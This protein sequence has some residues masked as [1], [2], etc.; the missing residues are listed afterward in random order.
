LKP[1][2]QGA[3]DGLCAVYSVVNATR[4]IS[5]IDEKE[6]RD[7]FKR[8]LI[9]LEK[10]EDLSR[11]LTEGIGLA[12]IGGILRDVVGDGI[13]NRSMPF[14]HFPNT[15]LDEFWME[16]LSFLGGGPKRAVLICLS[17]LM[18]DHWSIVHSISEK[19]IFFFDSHRLKRLNRSRCT[20]K[21][22]TTSRPH[23]LCPTHTY[24]LS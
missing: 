1:Y 18:W 11:L 15:S 16:M 12:T 21:Q 24:F 3:L 5:G 4:I 17:G 19:Q 14:K 2:L 23:V 7:L 8:I 10:N 9:Y 20:T 13:G 22:G 6:A